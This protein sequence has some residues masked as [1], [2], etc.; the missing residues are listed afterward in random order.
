MAHLLFL[1]Q[2]VLCPRRS[3]HTI[4]NVQDA[5]VSIFARVIPQA[6][7]LLVNQCLHNPVMCRN[8]LGNCQRQ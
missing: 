4:G 2:L 3:Y 6:T 5:G 8:M 7:E 1:S